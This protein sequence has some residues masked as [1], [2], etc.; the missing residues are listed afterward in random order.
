MNLKRVDRVFCLDGFNQS[1]QVARV[2]GPG[3]VFGE[4][5]LIEK[6]LRTADVRAL[7]DCQA[8]L[9]TPKLI[10]HLKQ[11]EG[12]EHT[13]LDRIFISQHMASSDL[14]KKLPP[15]VIHIFANKGVVE[16]LEPN[17]VIIQQDDIG[18]D[19]Y[20]LLRG[21]VDI[22]KNAQS[23]RS[24]EQGGFFG[25]IALLADTP[26]TATVKTLEATSILKIDAASF[27]DVLT[28]NINMATMIENVAETRLEE[29]QHG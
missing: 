6:T 26:R 21:K 29:V 7:S 27:W 20:L 3:A 10:E 28:N 2:I 18:T 5:G 14:F 8:M 25:E 15:E 23:I 22:E 24:I 17:H 13:V 1:P 16:H 11:H 12:E 9:L 19:F 4:M